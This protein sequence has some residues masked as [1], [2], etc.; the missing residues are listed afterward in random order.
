MVRDFKKGIQNKI[1]KKE[2]KKHTYTDGHFT[3]LSKNFQFPFSYRRESLL[4]SNS[5]RNRMNATEECQLSTRRIYRRFPLSSFV[6]QYLFPSSF[7]FCPLIDRSSFKVVFSTS[8]FSVRNEIRETDNRKQSKIKIDIQTGIRMDRLN[9][10]ID[11]QTKREIK[12]EREKKEGAVYSFLYLFFSLLGQ[13]LYRV[14]LTG[15]TSPEF[16]TVRST[17]DV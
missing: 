2:R 3:Y 5:F 4:Q 9:E 13:R 7:S 11:G 10:Q 17:N 15:G 16:F 6:G 1:I 14:A 12:K 8:N